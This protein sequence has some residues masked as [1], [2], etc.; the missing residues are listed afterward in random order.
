MQAPITDDTSVAGQK[1]LIHRVLNA[2]AVG[3]TPLERVGGVVLCAGLGRRMGTLTETTPKPLLPVLNCPLLW[4]NLARMRAEVQRVAVNVHHLHEA[5]RAS[6]EMCRERDMRI[7]LVYEPELTGPLG[8]VLACRH[9]LA[10]ADYFLV[11]AGDG[12]YNAD[13][14]GILEQHRQQKAE[15]TICVA[16]V[17]DGSRYG[18]VSTDHVGRVTHMSEKPPGV[19]CVPN[20]SCGVYVVS[21]TLVERFTAVATS[22]DWIDV[23]PTLIEEGA[24]VM[25]ARI[26]DWRDIGNQSDLLKANMDLLAGEQIAL[27]ARDLGLTAASVWSQ[28]EHRAD[29]STVLFE[30]RVLLG[31][32]AEIGPRAVI[33]NSVIGHGARIEAEAV[34]R[35]AVILPGSRVPPCSTVLGTI[36]A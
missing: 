21:K 32:N 24:V 25:S 17:E 18:I 3:R 30:G 10:E 22:L 2:T 13:F 28:S 20:A 14:A 9:A 6:I 35:N 33:E 19:G 16:L 36:W 29:L 23:V 4:W 8:G 5:F 27:V 11:F 7:E 15:L 1:L 34:V 12:L 26:D 31:I